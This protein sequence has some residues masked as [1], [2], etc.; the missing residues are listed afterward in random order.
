MKRKWYVRLFFIFALGTATVL[1]VSAQDEGLDDGPQDD[2]RPMAGR[3]QEPR[4]N[5][6]RQLGL[7]RE[8]IQRIRRLNAARRPLVQAA[9]E[10]FREANRQLDAA[11]YADEVNE[12]D[13]RARLK[14]V[15][16]AHAELIRIRSMDELAV[17]RLLTAEQLITFRQLR[18]RFHQGRPDLRDNRPMQ[19][20]A[21]GNGYAPPTDVKTQMPR[22]NK[23]AKP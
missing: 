3:R 15:Q 21:P 18:N 7:S 2:D 19:G 16:L 12:E 17:R 1:G 14:D 11:I 8:Q 5:L 13:V 22:T 4:I 20:P 6:L 10:R 9:Q 23:N